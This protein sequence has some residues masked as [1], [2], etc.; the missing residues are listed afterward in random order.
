MFTVLR[1][2]KKSSARL[3]VLKTVHGVVPTPAFMAIATRGSVKSVAAHDLAA[4]GAD[5]VLANTYH[6]WLRPGLAV[7]KKHGGLHNFMGWN[8]PLLTD[9]GG[10]QV[11]SLA[12]LRTVT[13]R[14]VSFRD[15]VDGKKHLLTPE[16]SMEIQQVFGSDFVMA[17]DDVPGFPAAKK[18]VFGSMERTTRWAERC[19]N[20][21]LQKHQKR[22]GIVQGGVFPDLRKKHAHVMARLPFDA[23]AIGG[24]S[25]GEPPKLIQKIIALTAPL[26]PENKPRYV[27]GMGMPDQVIDAVKKGIDMFDCVLPTRDARHG[28]LYV[29]KNRQTLSWKTLNV[30]NAS[31]ARDTRPIDA[32]CS[33]PLCTHHTRSFLRHLFAISEPLGSRLAT[34]HNI[35]FYLELF[36]LM[37]KKITRGEL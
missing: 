9:S 34:L 36:V 15:P 1:R 32:S 11:F 27:M 13:E 17:F 10:F 18:D 14:G 19:L 5:I 31:F 30:K 29:W 25:V 35:T 3:G 16:R 21:K 2:S 6:L 7:L 24:V 26:L 12:K 33:C 20:V 28:R 8:G 23:F 37:R 4:L 22:F